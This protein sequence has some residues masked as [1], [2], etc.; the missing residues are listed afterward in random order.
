MQNLI[1]RIDAYLLQEEKHIRTAHY[2]SDAASCLR[3]LFFKWIDEP[4][5]NP[6]EVGTLWKFK[7]GDAMHDMMRT[8]LKEMNYELVSEIGERTMVTGLQY[9]ISWRLDV[10]FM[11]E[12]GQLAGIDFKTS[13][14]RYIVNLKDTGPKEHELTQ[15]AI[16]M[17]LNPV[18]ARF[19][20][21]YLA[22][23]SGY[24]CQYI[25]ERN[26]IS[27]IW[28]IAF[29]RLQLLEGALA[30]GAKPG[31]EY[32]LAIKNGEARDKFQKNKI[33]YKSNWQCNLCQWRDKCWAPELAKYAQGDNS[34]DLTEDSYEW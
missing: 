26:Q 21:V 5:S 32:Q 27:L 15:V 14:G 3:Q 13:F 2:P 11:D 1:D 25:V 9:P 33:I 10:L 23:D 12:D 20:L 8:F 30:N 28:E 6:I 17:K 4:V 18:I 24:R 19:Y 29:T 31:R 34:E 16:Y 22:R 7:M